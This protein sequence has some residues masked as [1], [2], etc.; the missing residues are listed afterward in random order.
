MGLV[1]Q[2]LKSTAETIGLRNQVYQGGESM[3]GNTVKMFNNVNNEF[4]ISECFNDYKYEQDKFNHLWKI[5]TTCFNLL[6]T[7]NITDDQ[8]ELL[9][10]EMEKF[11]FFFPIYFPNQNLT[12]KM[13]CFSFVLPIYIR[14]YKMGYKMLQLEQKTESLH[15]TLNELVRGKRLMTAIKLY[16]KKKKIDMT[17]FNK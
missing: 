13:H 9:A 5:L 14:K 3:Q 1:E 2:K 4:T 11:T 8:N 17:L 15:H 7:Q 12:R 6:S 16:E 10:M